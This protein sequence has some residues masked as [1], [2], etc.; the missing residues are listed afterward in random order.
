M[1]ILLEILDFRLKTIIT[2]ALKT[3]YGN[4]KK[5]NWT[6]SILYPTDRVDGSGL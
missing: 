6:Q 2:T 4:L 1:E 3:W 5:S